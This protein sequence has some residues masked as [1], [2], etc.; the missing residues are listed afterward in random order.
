MS[1][2]PTVSISVPHEYGALVR[3]A[4]FLE[5]LA[6]DLAEPE[7]IATPKEEVPGPS[8]QGHVHLGQPAPTAPAPETSTTTPTSDTAPA[9]PA[10]TTPANSTVKAV[11]VDGEGLRFDNRIHSK[12]EKPFMASGPRKGFWKYKRNLDPTFIAQVE[13]ELRAE[14][15]A[16]DG[17]AGAEPSTG[18]TTE[19][20]PPPPPPSPVAD[21]PTPPPPPP[22]P[23]ATQETAPPPPPEPEPESKES[24]DVHTLM[25]EIG[26]KGI[27]M[28]ELEKVIK[29]R[30]VNSVPELFAA[31]ESTLQQIYWDLN[32]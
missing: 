15:D 7:D 20:A 29:A 12:A 22:P 28:D 17:T 13:A 16:A 31:N 23:A 21:K 30:D 19:T 1:E 3:A 6:R 10:S 25:A 8:N 11:E 4:E 9:P 5:G 14:R 26:A 32:L 18:G 24:I 2:K 27:P